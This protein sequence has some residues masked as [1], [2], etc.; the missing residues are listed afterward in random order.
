MITAIMMLGAGLGLGYWLSGSSDHA[1]PAVSGETRKPLFYRSPM[2]PEVTSPVPAKDAMGMDYVPVY[3]DDAGASGPAGT[4]RIDPVVVQNIGVRT[5]TAELRT[6]S[7]TID[8][9]GRIDY[10]EERLTRLHPKTEGWVEELR[11]DETGE[12]VR[13]G[14]I[15]LAF[16]SPQLVSSQNE[17]LI[18]LK[19]LETLQSSPFADVRLGAEEMV[20]SSLDRLRLLDVPQHQIREL[21]ESRKVKKLI[22]IHSPADG[23]VLRVGVRDGEYITPNKEIFMIADLR[24]IWAYV[25]IYENE[26]PWTRVGDEAEMTVTGIPGRTFRG[27]LAYIYPYADAKTRT[28]KVRMEFDN[29]ELLL[30]PDMFANVTIHADPRPDLVTVPSEAIVRSGVRDQVF[31]VRAPGRFEP[32]DVQV[33]VESDGLTEIIQGIQP[34]EKV[35]VSAQFLI[36]SESK[37]REA[38]AKMREVR[39]D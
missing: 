39:S 4:V 35:V 21:K 29:A 22:H 2:N 17:Y 8:T 32:R 37:L 23:V 27:K 38:T 25:D 18:A 10:D 26:L 12:Q 30:K 20:E 31:I 19:N 28:I 1:A 33:G 15:L 36:D 5:A 34:G 14:D 24:T 9:V 11:V 6:L 7:R 16:Y 3:A 13:K